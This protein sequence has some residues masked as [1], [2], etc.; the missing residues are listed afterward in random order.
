MRDALATPGEPGSVRPA[1]LDSVGVRLRPLGSW[2]IRVDLI[3]PLANRLEIGVLYP[4]RPRDAPQP[5]QPAEPA[6]H[7]HDLP[8]AAS[9]GFR[10]NTPGGGHHAATRYAH[11]PRRSFRRCS[12]FVAIDALR[13]LFQPEARAASESPGG[14][15]GLGCLGVV[16]P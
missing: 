12:T 10:A 13:P 1:A 7:H 14:D 8:A 6:L 16:G 11:Q 4:L 15:A 2:T 3:D 5:T 9:T